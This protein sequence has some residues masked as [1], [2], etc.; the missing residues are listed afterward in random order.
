MSKKLKTVI[1]IGIF[2]IAIIGAVFIYNTLSQN[3]SENIPPE[4]NDEE[5]IA[6]PDFSVQDVNG[7]K[8][9]LSDYF[10]KP[11]VL[12]FWASWCPS[13][14]K[15]MPHFDE[16]YSEVKDEVEFI[17]VDSVD[18]Q[19]ETVSTGKQFISEKGYL[20]PIYFDVTGEASYI[21]GVSSI[22]ATVFID[23]DGNVASAF[24]GA[25]SEEKLLNGIELI[26]D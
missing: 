12:N 21:Y 14:V 4:T 11:I 22:P 7:D 2:A 6:A 9:N 16:V 20:F 10:G 15:E 8:V 17:M 25:I 18:G 1:W 23:K 3:E 24:V 5:K 19:R 26:K 13:C